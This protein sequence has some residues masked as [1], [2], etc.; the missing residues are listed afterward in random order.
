LLE[1]EEE[2][3]NRETV[4]ESVEGRKRRKSQE[5]HLN[6][7]LYLCKLSCLFLWPT[8]TPP[9]DRNLNRDELSL[10]ALGLLTQTDRS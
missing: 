4:E 7:S 9:R 6:L 10:V 5:T 3:G 2:D 1:R 8:A